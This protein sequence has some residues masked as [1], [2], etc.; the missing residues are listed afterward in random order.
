MKVDYIIPAHQGGFEDFDEALW[1]KVIKDADA[2]NQAVYKQRLGLYGEL[3]EKTGDLYGAKSRQLKYLQQRNNAPLKPPNLANTLNKVL[4]LYARYQERVVKKEH[5]KDRNRR[6]AE[7]IQSLKS[8][9]LEAGRDY[10]KS[11]ALTVLKQ[12]LQKE[13]QQ[14]LPNF[15]ERYPL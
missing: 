5:I 7:A 8:R 1:R 4:K 14:T 9:G 2:H 3:L 15:D 12:V 11:R 6:R 13:A 10:K